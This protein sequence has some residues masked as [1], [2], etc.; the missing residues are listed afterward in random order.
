[1]PTFIDRIFDA[2]EGF[3]TGLASFSDVVRAQPADPPRLPQREMDRLLD[4]AGRARTAADRLVTSFQVV[5]QTGV[6]I[7][8][9]QVRIQG[10]SASLASALKAIGDTV[11]R[12]HFVR[13]T[14]A[15][16]LVDLDERAQLVAA[17]VFPSSVQGLRAVNVKLWEFDPL[18][19][20]RYT[21][22]LTTAVQRGT[23]TADQEARIQEIA[24]S[25]RLGFSRVNEFLNQLAEGDIPDEA[26]VRARR[27]QTELMMKG[28][29]AEAKRRLTKP[30][31][32]FRPMIEASGRVADAVGTLLHRMRIPVF[33]PHESLGVLTD[34]LAVDAYEA[35]TGPQRFALLNIASRMQATKVAGR[36]LLDAQYEIRV[37]R[38]F[39]DRIYF[40]AT[41]AIIEAVRDDDQF[42]VASA[43]LHR[44]NEGS[45][46]QNTFRR[47]NL[48]LSYAS[49]GND[50]V[51][52]DAD[53]DLYRD[54]IPHLFGEVLVNHLTGNVTDQFGVRK[55]L[56]DHGVEPI[57]GFVIV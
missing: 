21:D 30:Y 52:V 29:V 18:Q 16:A 2:L 6:D 4:L 41:R 17:A 14:F 19:W 22:T 40:D 45:F 26:T 44:F 33:P 20:K 27:K 11:E 7:V 31:R 25:V 23:L 12:Q 1:M 54:P 43:A 47:G 35:L 49:R 37:N 15:G 57:G 38:V 42:G 53:I 32:M 46:K 28:A 55:I 24:E 56:D 5:Q 48:Q 36:P 51:D 3:Q 9:I 13:E 10:E 39:P 34:G 50:R 8:D